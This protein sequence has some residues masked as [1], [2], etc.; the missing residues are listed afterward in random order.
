MHG[1]TTGVAVV[2]M[3]RPRTDGEDVPPLAAIPGAYADVE[4]PTAIGETAR[5]RSGEDENG[6]AWT[7]KP[8]AAW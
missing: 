7:A 2:V 8:A 1:Q 5:R 6:P 4:P 3:K